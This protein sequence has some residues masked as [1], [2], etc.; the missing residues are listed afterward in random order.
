MF[1]YFIDLLANDHDGVVQFLP[2]LVAVRTAYSAGSWLL[3]EVDADGAW[4]QEEGCVD[5]VALG[6]IDHAKGCGVCLTLQ[7]ELAV[8]DDDGVAGLTSLHVACEI[9]G[10]AIGKT[11]CRTLDFIAVRLACRQSEQEGTK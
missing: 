8:L 6:T 10:V 2:L 5:F 4:L 3:G 11:F 9:Q 1:C 7:R